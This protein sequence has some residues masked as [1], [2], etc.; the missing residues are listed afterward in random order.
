MDNEF[1]MIIKSKDLTL[2][3]K[4]MVTGYEMILEKFSIEIPKMID[5]HL[6]GMISIDEL[7]KEYIH[8]QSVK[9]ML[10]DKIIPIRYS[11]IDEKY[12]SAESPKTNKDLKDSD[13]DM[14]QKAAEKYNDLTT[15]F[16]QK[17]GNELNKYAA[18][19]MSEKELSE[20]ILH[21]GHLAINELFV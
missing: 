9:I 14:I 12:P 11:M 5:D 2:L 8:L 15:L 20:K 19:G 18:D 16:M 17:E 6:A 13:S 3:T 1:D 4:A 10:F 21:M 7:F